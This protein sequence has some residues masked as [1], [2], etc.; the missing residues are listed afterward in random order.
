MALNVKQMQNKAGYGIV[1]EN[2][3]AVLKVRIK[4]YQLEQLFQFIWW[5]GYGPSMVGGEIYVEMAFE[6][7]LNNACEKMTVD[8]YR[9]WLKFKCNFWSSYICDAD[10]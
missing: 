8:D 6:E 9:E 7:M 3:V 1:K 2:D 4:R 5:A 10:D